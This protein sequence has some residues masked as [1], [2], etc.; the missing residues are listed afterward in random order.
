[1]GPYLVGAAG[2]QLHLHQGE[3]PALLQHPVAGA[4]G[5]GALLGPLGHVHPVLG[6]VLLQVAGEGGLLLLEMAAHHAQV[7]LVHLPVL[8]LLV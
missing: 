5:L 1:M 4:D 8:H 6:L 7:E 3:A 2:E